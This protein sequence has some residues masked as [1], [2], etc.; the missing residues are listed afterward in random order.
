MTFYDELMS[1]LGSD[2]ALRLMAKYGGVHI[3]IPMPEGK[4]AGFNTITEKI[5]DL[6]NEG[7]TVISISRRL[8]LQPETVIDVLEEILTN[9]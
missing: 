5:L 4:Q 7:D 3:Y 1:A 2:L 6:Y 9:E 8:H